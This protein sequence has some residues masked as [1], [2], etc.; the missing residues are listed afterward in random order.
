M[1]KTF[2]KIV[3]YFIKKFSGSGLEQELNGTAAGSMCVPEIAPAARLAAAESA[4]LL[5]NDGTLP[6]KSGETVSVFGRTAF[7]YFT[8]G[9]G[10]G[11]DIIAPYK[12][13]V[14]EGLKNVILEKFT[15]IGRGLTFFC[16]QESRYSRTSLSTKRSSSLMDPIFSMASMN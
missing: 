7:D 10:S 3:R 14:V 2:N 11:G 5:M 15:D 9:Y 8:V 12:V 4:V 16:L 13:N 1:G 6:L